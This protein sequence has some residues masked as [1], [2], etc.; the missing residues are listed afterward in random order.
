MGGRRDRL[1]LEY[2]AAFGE[3]PYDVIDL[4]KLMES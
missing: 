4:T 1:I 3:N 2:Y